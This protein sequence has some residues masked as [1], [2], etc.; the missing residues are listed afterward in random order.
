LDKTY[1]SIDSEL[2]I[3]N[4]EESFFIKYKIDYDKVD[5]VVKLENSV[6]DFE[7]NFKTYM[8]D[9]G[10]IWNRPNLIKYKTEEFLKKR[11]SLFS[12]LDLD[13]LISLET[14]DNPDSQLIKKNKDFLRELSIRDEIDSIL[15][16]SKIFKLNA[17]YNLIDIEILDPGFGC[18]MPIPTVHISPPEET[19]F[20]FGLPSSAIAEIGINGE[21]TKI[22]VNKI[23]CNYKKPP[24]IFIEGFENGR[25]P[26]LKPIIVNTI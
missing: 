13:F 17:F 18:S 6:S 7:L 1:K 25:H 19:D 2:K 12:K 9:G 10:Q 14:K 8:P 4:N 20:S 21:L 24:K 3:D 26:V 23:G 11:K 5:Y 22:D 16:C 15:D